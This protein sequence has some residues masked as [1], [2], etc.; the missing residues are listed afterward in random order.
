MSPRN[1]P[2]FV[3]EVLVVYHQLTKLHLLL[4]FA[5]D[6]DARDSGARESGLSACTV[7][8]LVTEVSLQP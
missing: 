5:R 7:R 6:S 4:L 1:P 2:V 8:T 3:S